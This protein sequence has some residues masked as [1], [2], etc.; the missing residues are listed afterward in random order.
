MI[1]TPATQGLGV[2]VI[3]AVLLAVLELVRRVDRP[4]DPESPGAVVHICRTCGR[5]LTTDDLF[6]HICGSD[7][8]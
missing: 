3:V 1:G 7:H 4:I 2:L 8:P 5:P 6:T